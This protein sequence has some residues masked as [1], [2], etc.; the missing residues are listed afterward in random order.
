MIAII[1]LFAGFVVGWFL[2]AIFKHS[3][4]ADEAMSNA[5]DEHQAK[6]N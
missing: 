5:F 1:T 6:N 3:K 2:S 4:D